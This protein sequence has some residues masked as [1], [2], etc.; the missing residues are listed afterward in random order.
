M[1]QTQYH[2]GSCQKPEYRSGIPNH[3]RAVRRLALPSL[4]LRGHSH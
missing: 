3:H 1:G 2:M 4:S